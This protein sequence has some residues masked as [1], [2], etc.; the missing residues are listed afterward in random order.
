M[1]QTGGGRIVSMRAGEPVKPGEEDTGVR[2]ARCAQTD[3][4]P[5]AHLQHGLFRAA[6]MPQAVFGIH[7]GFN[8]KDAKVG[9]KVRKDGLCAHRESL[10]VL[11]VKTLARKRPGARLQGRMIRW[12]CCVTAGGIGLVMTTAPVRSNGFVAIRVH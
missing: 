6:I 1:D 9:A 3:D 10:R 5:T 4:Q 11:R 7:S 12:N 2:V 8:A